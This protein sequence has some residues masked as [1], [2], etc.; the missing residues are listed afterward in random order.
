[1]EHRNQFRDHLWLFHYILFIF[2]LLFL[3]CQIPK[4]IRLS[5][6]ISVPYAHVYDLYKVYTQ[7][8]TLNFILLNENSDDNSDNNMLFRI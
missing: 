8:R 3:V 7:L 1:M 4:A 5:T 2:Y 6:D